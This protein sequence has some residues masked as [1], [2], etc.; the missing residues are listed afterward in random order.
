MR[1]IREG[2]AICGKMGIDSK[3]EKANRPY[4]L[5]LFISVPMAKKIYGDDALH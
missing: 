2:L 3:A 1:A 5:P 4:H